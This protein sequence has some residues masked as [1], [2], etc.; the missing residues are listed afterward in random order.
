MHNR[1]P[2]KTMTTMHTLQRPLEGGLQDDSCLPGPP[3]PYSAEHQ[4][5]EIQLTTRVAS[6]RALLHWVDCP[7]LSNSHLLEYFLGLYFL[8]SCEITHHPLL[9]SNC[10]NGVPKWTMG[11]RQVENESV[12]GCWYLLGPLRNISIVDSTIEGQ[13]YQQIKF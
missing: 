12:Y 2:I 10:S 8:C 6:Y 4:C 1:K 11:C 7:C 3:L 13:T 5:S 9:P